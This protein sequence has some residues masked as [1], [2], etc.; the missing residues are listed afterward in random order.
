MNKMTRIL[1]LVMALILAC[2]MI[3]TAGAEDYGFI[4]KKSKPVKLTVHENSKCGL[5]KGGKIQ[6][7]MAGA[8]GSVLQ[9]AS[10]DSSDSS[11]AMVNSGGTIKATRTGKTKLTMTA[12]TGETWMIVGDF[13]EGA[14]F[15]FPNGD[16]INIVVDRLSLKKQDLVEVFGREFVGIG[17]VGPNS[18]CKVVK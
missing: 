14:M 11:V 9:A 16:D 1:S 18:F 3:S 12:T 15:N 17:V 4:G 10:F 8:D 6:L 5:A 13:N 2:A 7:K